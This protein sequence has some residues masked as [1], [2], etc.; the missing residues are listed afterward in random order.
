M[1]KYLITGGAGF[2]GSNL[3][4][5]IMNDNPNSEITIVDDLSMGKIENLE[6]VDKMNFIKKS[7]TDF[8]FMSDLLITNNYD[9]IILLG[10]V[11]SVA[12]SVE[13]PYETHLINQDANINILETIRKNRLKVR[14]VLFSSSAA[15]YGN[16]PI[17]PKNEN[18]PIDPL[19]PY[20][21]D[22]YASER[23]LI[24]YG[25]LYGINTVATRFF[26]V[27]GPN[28]NPSSPYSGV[29]SILLDSLE[30]DKEFNIYGDGNQTRDFTF[31]LDV[32]DAILLLLDH[33]KAMNDVY[34]VATG[35]SV[36]L[37]EVIETF[38]KIYNKKLKVRYKNVRMGDIKESVA[39]V[40]KLKSL[41][42]NPKFNIYA[43][44]EAYVQ[45]NN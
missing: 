36:T 15:V 37:N 22:K 7:I 40:T 25:K 17:L 39:D 20:A 24:N 29:L 12:D 35:K 9:Y 38:Q 41:G 43:G 45:K 26:N 42:F 44:L 23:Y 5:K 16:N 28:Q 30:N 6:T 18:S 32:V 14:K 8:D 13:R 33:P 3:A 27:Y 34:N 11:A 19:T 4:N 2:I 31:V 1:M 21:I 10:A